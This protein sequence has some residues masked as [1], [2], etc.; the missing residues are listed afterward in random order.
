MDRIHASTHEAVAVITAGTTAPSD[1]IAF[2]IDERPRPDY[3]LVTTIRE[4]Q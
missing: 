4:T 2:G 1:S 3:E